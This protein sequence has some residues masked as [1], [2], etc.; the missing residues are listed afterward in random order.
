MG[1]ADLQG[2]S[3]QHVPRV[4]ARANTI[5]EGGARD[6]LH[7]VEATAPVLLDRGEDADDRWVA[8]LGQ[9]RGAAEEAPADPRVVLVT[10][11]EQL[12]GDDLAGV[13]VDGAPHRGDAALAKLRVEAVAAAQHQPRHMPSSG[14]PGVVRALD[15]DAALRPGG[16]ETGKELFVEEPTAYECEGG[17]VRVRLMRRGRAREA[18]DQ[19]LAVASAI[20]VMSKLLRGEQRAEEVDERRDGG[21]HGVTRGTAVASYANL[22]P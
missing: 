1:V 2:Q 5:I 10:W 11:V 22:G 13:I 9:R 3:D 4:S 14:E 18:V 21:V 6:V 12:D 19:C 17:R 7:R 15:V 20:E 8:Q 16:H